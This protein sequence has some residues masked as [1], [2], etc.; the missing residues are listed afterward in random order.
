[1]NDAAVVPP[2]RNEIYAAI[3][4]DVG[5]LKDKRKEESTAR[6]RWPYISYLP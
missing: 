4:I 1:M 2:A 3:R 5:C 6:R